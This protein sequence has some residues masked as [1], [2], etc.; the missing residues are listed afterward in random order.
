MQDE[1]K[2]DSLSNLVRIQLIGH[3]K[4]SML[5]G[6]TSV[7]IHLHIF[8]SRNVLHYSFLRCTVLAVQSIAPFVSRGSR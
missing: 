3:S 8:I 6:V 4:G 7:K 5:S 1:R 2:S